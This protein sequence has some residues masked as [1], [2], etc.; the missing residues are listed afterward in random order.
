MPTPPAPVD[1]QLQAGVGGAI[2]TSPSDSPTASTHPRPRTGRRAL[3][4]LF[5]LLAI[6][7]AGWCLTIYF[8]QD[9]LVFP[10]DAAGPPLADR[11]IPPE[12]ERLWITAGDGSRVEAWFFP[13]ASVSRSPRPTALIFHGN[14]EL[15]D[16]CAADVRFYQE[17]GF[18]VLVPEYRG[19]GRSTGSPSQSALTADMRA[20]L[21]L[22]LARSDV[23]ATRLVYHGRSLGAAVAVQLAAHRAPAALIL[24]S[25]FSSLTSMAWRMGIPPFVVRSPFDTAAVLPALPCPILLLHSADDEIIPIWHAERLHA[26]APTST[27]IRL[28]GSHNSGLNAQPAYRES[29]ERVL[30]LLR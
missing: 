7:Y 30:A 8:V 29:V 5:V 1:A 6:L 10:R 19:Y 11:D 22:L 20:F 21:S 18:S 13:A 27:L 9:R 23:D 12:A 4:R 17:R 14:A 15:I 3:R 2:L 16:H 25:P 28:H 26:L 24:E